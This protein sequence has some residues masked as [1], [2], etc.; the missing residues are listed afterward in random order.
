M[1]KP[2]S[3]LPHG[4]LAREEKPT[5][6]DGLLDPA[7]IAARLARAMV[8]RFADFAAIQLLD[9]VVTG[10]TESLTPKEQLVLRRV[11]VCDGG[12][13][14][15]LSDLLPEGEIVRWPRNSPLLVTL[16]GGASVHVPYIDDMTGD[17]LAAQLAT[18]GLGGV[19]GRRPV[20]IVPML[21][22]GTMIG[23]A[24]L[25]G[26]TDRRRFGEAD[27]AAVEALAQWAADWIDDAGPCRGE[28]D[29]ARELWR[30]ARPEI[31][32]RVARAE[33][34]HRYLPK[35]RSADLGGDWVDVIPL[36][37]DRVALVAGD[38]A[39]HGVD[40]AALMS[41]CKTVVRT[42][43]ALDLPPG[44]L[45][46]HF[47]TVLSR[48]AGEPGERLVTCVYA[49]YDPAAGEGVFESYRVPV[50]DGALLALCTDGL[51]EATTRDV[52]EGLELLRAELAD[53]GRHLERI[54]D[55]VIARLAG[56]ERRDDVALLL[57]RLLG[58]ATSL[59]VSSAMAAGD[60][61][62]AGS[63]A[64]PPSRPA[65]LI[66]R[67]RELGRIA[68]L[69]GASRLV[70]LTG[71]GG[72]GKSRLAA[73]AVDRLRGDFPDGVAFVDVATVRTPDL[74]LH[75]VAD[76]VG[77][78]DVPGRPRLEAVLDHLADNRV[79]LVLD[80]CEHQID[81][82]AELTTTL[83]R[84]SHR[85]RVLVTGRQPLRAAGEHILDVA[86]LARTVRGSARWSDAAQLFAERAAEV[87]PGFTLS[88]DNSAAV[89]RIC[90]VAEGVPLAIELA[91]GRLRSLTLR[92]VA[93][94][95][96]DRFG[97]LVAETPAATPRH[98]SL[99]ASLDWSHR[100]CDPQ[101]ALL[102]TRLS[103]F[104]DPFDLGAV[105]AVCSDELLPAEDIID[106]LSALLEK[107]VVLRE[108]SGERTRYRMPDAV[109]DYGAEHG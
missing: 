94:G 11:A 35:S 14:R 40:A 22:G 72:V 103:A 9:E 81:A 99:R 90:R 53:P 18:P 62:A 65:R 34:C 93:E 25:A 42:L 1:A 52:G 67:D 86:P 63:A 105:E 20:L 43:A 91:A 46:R 24:L 48:S 101:E 84:S 102:W 45:L 39:G 56:G 69:L 60:G 19:L 7:R 68:R 31:P 13:E 71:L 73:Y 79:L 16:S 80:T 38:V 108:T 83:L 95:T 26:D 55:G 27:I 17:H 74:L 76:A 10:G 107:S 12:T 64:A 70:T 100:L 92:E 23:V 49:V 51:V 54:C 30:E 41:Q 97:L 15:R 66:G 98:Q 78:P 50:G 32:Q 87:L 4:S 47:D 5:R 85:L 21:A 106:L 59:A 88:P 29:I 75:A 3:A 37:G 44:E 96:R 28:H 77:A 104:T 2:A 8:P 109:R 82:C 6:I 89:L 61:F 58:P 33:L 57:A 36:P